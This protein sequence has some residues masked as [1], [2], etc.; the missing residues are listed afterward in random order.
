MKMPSKKTLSVVVAVLLLAAAAL[1][2]LQRSGA[3]APVAFETAPVQRGPLAATV[4]ATG[5]LSARVTVLVGAQVSG[6][7]QSLS[8][9]YNSQVKKGD[10]I[11]QLDPALFEAA[12]DQAKASLTSAQASLEKARAQALDSKR[13]LAR[14][15]DLFARD[16][17]SKAEVEVAETTLAVN[18]SAVRQAQAALEQARANLTQANVNLTYTTIRS[19]ISGTVISRSVDVGQTVASSLQAPTLFTIAEDLGKME[20]HTSVSEADVGRLAAGM[21][22][23]FTV[24]A[25][26]N[27][28]FPGE[29][30]EIRNAAT[31]VQNVVTYDAVV[32]VDNPQLKLRP[33]MTANV[34]VTYAQRESALK[35]ANAALRFQPSDAVLAK[36]R[37]ARSKEGRGGA[38]FPPSAQAAEGAS[39][40]SGSGRSGASGAAGTAAGG[41]GAGGSAATAGTGRRA[42]GAAAAGEKALWVLRDGQ[43]RRVPVKVGLSDGRMS[44]VEGELKEGDLVVTSATLEGEAAGTAPS[45]RAPNSPLGGGGG[46]GPRGAF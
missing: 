11:A 19:P 26:P 18:D 29:V 24:D 31:T 4:T 45:T 12:R 1:F 9:D 43:P 35:V 2:L 30:R 39:A 22:V 3:D 37:E 13:Q 33:G 5:A 42:R 34:T 20:I 28:R 16:I 36:L 38:G 41:S 17:V 25:F 32:S 44:E 6:R 8:A 15:Q 21:P 14:T 23:T 10:V 7:I 27:E 46:R 40:P